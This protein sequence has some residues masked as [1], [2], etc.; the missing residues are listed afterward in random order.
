MRTVCIKVFASRES[1]R[2][3]T[4]F[5][6]AAAI[7]WLAIVSSSMAAPPVSPAVATLTEKGLVKKGNFWIL[8]EEAKLLEFD[9][10]L[11]DLEKRCR[12]AQL[13]YDETVRQNKINKEQYDKAKKEYEQIQ[14]LLKGGGLTPQQQSN[15]NTEAGKR[16]PVIQKLEP[17]LIDLTNG[18]QD[19]AFRKM[20]ADLNA[21]RSELILA[22]GQ[23]EEN[24]PDALDEK[25]QAVRDDEELKAALAKAGPG[26]KL[27]PSRNFKKDPIKTATAEKLVFTNSL[28]LYLDDQRLV[29]DVVL[30]DKLTYPITDGRANDFTMLPAKVIESSGQKITEDAPQ[31]TLNANKQA[32]KCRL[33]KLKSMR[34]GKYVLTD[35]EVVALPDDAALLQPAIGRKT[36]VD[37][38]MTSEAPDCKIIIKSNVDAEKERSADKKGPA[39]SP[40]PP[41]TLPKAQ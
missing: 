31:I 35:V 39:K 20:T 38:E 6:A 17:L 5:L 2:G 33:V 3:L 12:D 25:Y 29:F 11:K 8:A 21:A 23:V 7:L 34:L 1:A 19:G 32:Y 41:P 10:S 40:G 30:N 15:L 37:Y 26:A 13:V 14:K 24:S 9:K 18:R 16:A 22:L 4:A 28:P 36:L 27:G